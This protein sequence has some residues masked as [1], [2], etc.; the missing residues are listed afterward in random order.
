MEE[1]SFVAKNDVVLRVDFIIHQLEFVS[2]FCAV[3]PACV[4]PPPFP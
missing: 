1:L 3:N 2:W 4:P